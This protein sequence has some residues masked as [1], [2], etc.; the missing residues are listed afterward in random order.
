MARPC[1]F[2]RGFVPLDSCHH[3]HDKATHN[4]MNRPQEP[5]W[6]SV[7]GR[8]RAGRA[9]QCGKPG[10]KPHILDFSAT[11]DI[12]G[13]DCAITTDRSKTNCWYH[14]ATTPTRL[15]V[16]FFCLL[17]LLICK[18]SHPGF[19][20]F[21]ERDTSRRQCDGFLETCDDSM[22]LCAPSALR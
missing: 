14:P 17:P 12:E 15:S 10:W 20:P 9:G 19:V 7:V 21:P 5:A 22:Q 8:L 4:R 11:A 16:S 18:L 6:T 1:L 2:G 13:Q 3:V